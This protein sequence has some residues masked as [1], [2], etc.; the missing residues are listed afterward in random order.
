MSFPEAPGVKCLT[1]QISYRDSLGY[2]TNLF[3][4]DARLATAS[5]ASGKFFVEA[6]GELKNRDWINGGVAYHVTYTFTDEFIEKKIDLV[7]HDAFPVVVITEPFIVQPGMHFKKESDSKVS[8]SGGKR[9]FA[10]TTDGSAKL[11]TGRDAA[12]Y[13]T[14]YPAIRAFPV[15]LEIAPPANGFMKSVT[16]RVTL[17]K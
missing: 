1:P 8:I 3:E 4:F 15:E 6:T 12:D 5:L 7:Y 17:K 11:I 2:F 13:W 9:E 16:Y 10:F 14:P